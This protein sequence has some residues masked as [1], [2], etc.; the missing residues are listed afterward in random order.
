M[1]NLVKVGMTPNIKSL[2][3]V[4]RKK[5]KEGFTYNKYVEFLQT[6]INKETDFF[7]ENPNIVK[8]YRY[9]DLNSDQIEYLKNNFKK[10][11]QHFNNKKIK[12]Y[13][14]I[15]FRRK[16]KKNYN[17]KKNELI[18]EWREKK[19]DELEKFSKFRLKDDKSYNKWASLYNMIYQYNCVVPRAYS[20]ES[21]RKIV[22][23][24]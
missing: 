10:L 4:S 21:L 15:K 18:E 2:K 14:D 24:L 17:K 22:L 20:R 16:Q 9:K 7:C 19:L 23:N 5:Y 1:S 3:E 6:R 11:E 12:K 8:V 13:L